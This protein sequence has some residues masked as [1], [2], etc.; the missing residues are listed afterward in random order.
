MLLT[1]GLAARKWA[2]T[3]FDW[4][5]LATHAEHAFGMQNKFGFTKSTT[6]PVEAAVV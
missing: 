3:Q 6:R 2:V 4:D 5:A 1:R